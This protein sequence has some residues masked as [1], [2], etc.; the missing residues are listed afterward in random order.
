MSECLVGRWEV[1]GENRLSIIAPCLTPADGQ[2]SFWMEIFIFF[3]I[4][5]STFFTKPAER[6][7]NRK[8]L[9]PLM[10]LECETCSLMLDTVSIV[11]C[12][13]QLHMCKR[14]WLCVYA[15]VLDWIFTSSFQFYSWSKHISSRSQ[16]KSGKLP[17]R[18]TIDCK[19]GFVG[20]VYLSIVPVMFTMFIFEVN[21]IMHLSSCE[22]FVSLM[23]QNTHVVAC[24]VGKHK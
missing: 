11:F 17:Q 16:K 21:R 1:G 8:L 7:D 6:P 20:S 10:H 13:D 12:F 9:C 23:C 5:S 18:S 19:Y 24:W 4:S 15:H 14:L 3:Q 22:P 2:D